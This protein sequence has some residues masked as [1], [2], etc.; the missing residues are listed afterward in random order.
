M[1]TA[2]I[3]IRSQ[4]SRGG[5]NNKFGGPDTYVAVQIVP[6]GVEPLKCL[7]QFAAKKR[8]IEILYCGEGYYN[9]QQTTRSMLGK[10]L[11]KARQIAEEINNE[12]TSVCK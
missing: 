6:E 5:N 7:N 9:R 12:V 10:A 4:G 11:A 1:K 2:Y 3:E 8:G